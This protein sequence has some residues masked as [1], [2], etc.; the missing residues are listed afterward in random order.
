M[1]ALS[2]D[3]P[4]VVVLQP[5]VFTD[6][7]GSF[8]K[9]YHAD[10]FRELGLPFT[11]C[12][13]F[14]SVSAKGVVRGM[15]FQLPPAAHDKLVYCVA[16]AVL[17]VVV[18]L[19]KESPAFGRFLARE[20]SEAN[21]EMFFIPIGCAHGFLALSDGATMVYQ[22]SSVH[23]PAHDAGILWNSF[24]FAW[25]TENPVLSERDR[26]FPALAAFQTPF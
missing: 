25:P 19:R 8:V 26:K 14:F 11:P 22:T 12:E 21:R 4:G 6:A 1:N 20:L 2:T 10:L 7:R 23:S 15:H 9:T 3:L 13:E 5:R 24:G 18:D 17:D 16:G